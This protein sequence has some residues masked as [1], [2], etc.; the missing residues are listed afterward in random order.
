MSITEDRNIT[1]DTAAH[2]VATTVG[3]TPAAAETSAVRAIRWFDIVEV[4]EVG[5]Q[6]FCRL[7]ND[8]QHRDIREKAMA[9]KARRI[10]QLKHPDSDANVVL[11]S[12]IDQIATH[13]DAEELL[14]GELLAERFYSDRDEARL[15]VEEREDFEHIGQDR[16]RWRTLEAMPEEERPAEEWRELTEHISE[17]V[18]A[19]DNR[20]SEIQ[21]PQR[22][23]L[24]GLGVNGMADKVRERRIEAEARRSF[25]EV[26]DFWQMYAGTLVVPDDFDPDN[27]T[28]ATTP[29]ERY[30]KS[31]ESLREA[32]PMIVSKLQGAFDL[33]EGGMST[34]TAGNS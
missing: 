34:L 33:L 12:E 16:E 15:D 28:A 17:Y 1:E 10:R 18:V 21:K 3:D 11:E 14:I 22:E 31:E 32:D 30:F 26:Y 19:V 20:L 7:P 8:F 29:R 13:P 2:E 24:I 9:A 25:K 23:A 27:I 4:P 5:F 6:A